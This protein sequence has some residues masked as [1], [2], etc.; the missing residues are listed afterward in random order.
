MTECA[1]VDVLLLTQYPFSVS[2]IRYAIRNSRSPYCQPIRLNLVRHL[3]V[4]VL[5]L[6]L[7]LLAEKVE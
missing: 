3:L 4:L 7:L 1:N 5:V 6:L 2:F